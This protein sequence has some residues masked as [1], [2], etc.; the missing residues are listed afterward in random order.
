MQI[1]YQDKIFT[2]YDP[3]SLRSINVLPEVLTFNNPSKE[4]LLFRLLLGTINISNNYDMFKIKQRINYAQLGTK[5]VGR[6]SALSI[7]DCQIPLLDNKDNFTKYMKRNRTNH[8]IYDKL[9]FEFSN[10][11]YQ[12]SKDSNIAAFVH[13]YRCIEFISYTFPLVYAS[14]SNNYHGTYKALKSFFS[15]EQKSELKF[16][17]A[18]QK[19]LIDESIL[20]L[21]LVLD[22]ITPDEE[23]GNRINAILRDV[24][25]G[26]HSTDNG[27]SI[28]INYGSLFDFIITLRNR[29][30]HMLTGSGNRN[31]DDTSIC[32]EYLFKSINDHVANW[33]AYIYYEIT[34]FGFESL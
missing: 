18:F 12:K 2:Y 29:Y 33:I 6:L 8:E 27:T 20:N 3:L 1:Q 26:L 4:A 7:G 24:C 11:F 13:L 28:S 19:S 14:K 5:T 23:M 25:F 10:Y 34:K 9:L 21:Q 16:F 30:F 17:K 31:I 22:I 15:E 32:I